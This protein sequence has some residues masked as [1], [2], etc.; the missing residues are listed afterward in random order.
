MPSTPQ[1]DESAADLIARGDAMVG[2]NWQFAEG[3]PFYQRAAQVEPANLDA[4]YSLARAH[5]FAGQPHE[6]LAAYDRALTTD[7][8]HRSAWTFKGMTLGMLG[9]HEEALAAY[10]HAL[11]IQPN[12]GVR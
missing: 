3:I 2:G 12:N 11:A 5:F 10:D 4:W 1:P 6:A 8:H 9:R 7:P